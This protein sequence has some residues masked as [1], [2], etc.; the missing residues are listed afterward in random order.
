ME[1]F[2][3]I[4]IQDEDTVTTRWDKFIHSHHYD[5]SNNYFDSLLA[6]NPRRTSESYFQH[7]MPMTVEEA[8]SESNPIPSNLTTLDE[9]WAW[10]QPLVEA[11]LDWK[12]ENEDN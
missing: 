7:M 6:R 12:K 2:E 9:L 8:F 3:I 5:Y 4:D 10:H 1:Q 11:E